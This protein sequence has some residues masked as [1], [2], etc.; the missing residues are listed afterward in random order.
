M[1]NRK[2][3][4]VAVLGVILAALIIVL[5][6]SMANDGAGA[7]AG[8]ADPGEPPVTT[9]ISTPLPTVDPTVAAEMN[10]K[11]KQVTM[12]QGIKMHAPKHGL[13]GLAGN[14]RGNGCLKQYGGPGQCLPIVSLAQQAMPDMDHPWDCHQVKQLFPKGIKVR[15]NDTL[16]LDVNGDG[17]ACGRGDG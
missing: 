3:G 4:V 7:S 15:T 17:T 11:M 13:T 9:P 6:I 1:T 16:G 10:G 5:G 2:A 12:A 8:A 14:G